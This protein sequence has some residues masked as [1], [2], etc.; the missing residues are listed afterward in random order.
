MA[1]W[2][3]AGDPRNEAA[4]ARETRV[5]A[6]RTNWVAEMK[7][8][9]DAAAILRAAGNDRRTERRLESLRTEWKYAARMRDYVATG[10]NP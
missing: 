10:V 7:R 5:D 1:Y 9:E 2:T 8:I 4:K 3:I 6:A